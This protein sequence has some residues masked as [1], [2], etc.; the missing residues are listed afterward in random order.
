MV[1]SRQGSNPLKELF[2]LVTREDLLAMQEAVEETYVGD[3]VVNYIVDLIVAT[4]HNESILR[5]ASPRATLS[6][7]AM[8]KAV[9]R[10]RG[11]D[12]VVPADVRE[13]FIHTVAHRLVLSPRAQAQGRQ[14]EQILREILE[15][16]DA[17]K[18]R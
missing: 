12:Y 15:S 5:G 4:R 14:A 7:T 3:A 6:V 16:V 13:V 2:P 10:L 18:L 11:R 9:A 8:S 1:L 17:P